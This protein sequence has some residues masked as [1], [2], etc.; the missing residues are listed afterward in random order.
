MVIPPAGT[1]ASNSLAALFVARRDV[2]YVRNAGNAPLEFTK[3]AFEPDGEFS[4]SQDGLKA[5]CGK[6]QLAPGQ[7]CEMRIVF[8]PKEGS[9][10]ANFLIFDNAE[11]SPQRVALYG[12]TRVA[13]RGQLQVESYNPD[14]GRVP[15]GTYSV[16]GVRMATATPSQR[17]VLRNAGSGNLYVTQIKPPSDTSYT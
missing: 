14:F 7:T 2:V 1:A 13:V 16:S 6:G 4:T 11:N 17:I 15:V 5:P 10:R 9:R 8:H 3:F 12:Q